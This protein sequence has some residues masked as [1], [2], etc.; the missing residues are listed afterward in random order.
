M[1]GSAAYVP[2]AQV[3]VSGSNLASGANNWMLVANA[4]DDI[5]FVLAAAQQDVEIGVSDDAATMPTEISVYEAKQAS[6]TIWEIERGKFVWI[7]ASSGN[8][9]D[10]IFRGW[11]ARGGI[12]PWR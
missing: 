6:G 3:H 7:R 1:A 8:N 11:S 12:A 5:G 10:F 9:S 2:L 4:A